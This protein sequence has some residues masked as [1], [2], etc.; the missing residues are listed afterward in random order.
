M[1]RWRTIRLYHTKLGWAWA[2]YGGWGTGVYP[3]RWMA[4]Y[5]AFRGEK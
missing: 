4:I 3:F 5:A 2:D 1:K